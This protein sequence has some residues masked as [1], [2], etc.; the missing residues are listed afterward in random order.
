M[1]YER[2]LP[3]DAQTGPNSID[4]NYFIK[5]LHE[6][7]HLMPVYDNIQRILEVE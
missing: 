1:E 3:S 5:R 6:R 7:G 2:K 4:V